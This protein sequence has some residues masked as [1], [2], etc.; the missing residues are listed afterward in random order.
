MDYSERNAA[1]MDV[2]G[3]LF[4]NGDVP[5]GLPPEF[6]QTSLGHLFGEIWARPGLSVKLRSLVTVTAV[7]AL[8]RNAETRIHLRGALS[9][10]W[11]PEEL[12]EA[13]THIAYYA[14]FPTALEG[15]RIL[16]EVLAEAAS[17]DG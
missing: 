13:I 7:V 3:Q 2:A 8:G 6:I 5:S 15:H 10:G 4:P 17:A 16:A 12:K 1:A 14:G 11:T 9:I